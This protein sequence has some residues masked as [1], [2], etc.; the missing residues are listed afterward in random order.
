MGK[1]T[2]TAHSVRLR[3]HRSV[4]NPTSSPT[5]AVATAAAV[6]SKPSVSEP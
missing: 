1:I 5:N 6:Y 4:R 3:P 2:A